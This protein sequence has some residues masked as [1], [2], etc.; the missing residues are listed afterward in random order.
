MDT[1]DWND[2]LDDDEEPSCFS[3]ETC[4]EGLLQDA[5]AGCVYC[6]LQD[7]DEEDDE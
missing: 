2:F 4:L 6:R 3:R 1:A 5:P 7:L